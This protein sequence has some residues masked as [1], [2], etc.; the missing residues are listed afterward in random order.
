MAKPA[1]YPPRTP[2]EIAAINT[3]KYLIDS[4]FVFLDIKELDRIPNI[5]GY[6]DLLDQ[7]L[8][9]IGKL[10]VQVRKLPDNCGPN[11]KY[12]ME[13]SLF[14]YAVSSTLNPVLL[15]GV[16]VKEKRAY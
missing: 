11:P 9:P 12:Q 2:E 13:L 7:D 16:D 15:I 5:D 8:L 14:G 10:E 6:A 1:P 4:K 3:L